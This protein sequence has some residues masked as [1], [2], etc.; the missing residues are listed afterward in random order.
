MTQEQ[1]PKVLAVSPV[2]IASYPHLT[3][4]DEKFGGYK[5]TLKIPTEK[6][7]EAFGHLESLID[8][9]Y[10]E[11]VS[12]VGPKKARDLRKGHILDD[13]EDGTT[14]IKFA[15][16]Y[17]PK[18]F[19]SKGKYL[20]ENPPNIW[21]GSKLRIQYTVGEPYYIAGTGS[22][23]IK[24]YLNAVQVISL[25]A[26]GQGSSE[27]PFDTVEG[28]FEAPEEVPFGSGGDSEY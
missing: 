5:V 28:G 6:A 22:V 26:G 17:A 10:K 2:G 12:K 14:S 27:N 15:S 25:V 8:E 23:G 19:D 9:A 24:L 7:E 11:T 21:S 1:E 18:I 16:T 13:N 4:E 20:G 3:K